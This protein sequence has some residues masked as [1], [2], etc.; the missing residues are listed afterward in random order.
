[1]NSSLTDEY[2][3]QGWIRMEKP[4]CSINGVRAAGRIGRR[5]RAIHGVPTVDGCVAREGK[6]RSAD[7][8]H[9]HDERFKTY[10]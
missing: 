3:R 6:W 5:Y 2:G 4:V 10:S 8:L 1:M 7:F 9:V